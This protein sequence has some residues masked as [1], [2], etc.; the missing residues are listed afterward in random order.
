MSHEDASRST[1]RAQHGVLDLERL[2]ERERQVL[3]LAAAGFLDKQIGVELGISLNTLRTYWS[4]IRVKTGEAPRAALAAAYVSHELKNEGAELEGPIQHEGW[5][6][7]VK[8]GLAMASDAVNRLH[9]LECG[10]P[11]PRDSYRAMF[12]PEDS[13]KAIAAMDEV[14]EGKV[15]TNHFKL[16]IVAPDGI[17]TTALTVHG[18]RDRQGK[19]SKVIGYRARVKDWNRTEPGKPKAPDVRVGFWAKKLRSGQFIVP[20]DEFC[21]IYQVERKSPTLDRDIRS[22]YLPEDAER[23]YDFIDEAVVAGHTRASHDFRLVF[24]DS[25][26]LWVRLECFIESDDEGPVRANGTVLAFR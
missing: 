25:S 20:D 15:Q 23:A 24:P 6:Y 12:H 9:G 26:D 10:V 13:D 16:R 5:I 14:I 8:T 3:G 17:H 21:R 1:T 18:V 11:H 19:V 7:D 4:R 2:S 22:R